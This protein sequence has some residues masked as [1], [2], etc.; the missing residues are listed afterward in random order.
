[1]RSARARPAT[2]HVLFLPGGTHALREIAATARPSTQETA[3]RWRR[4]APAALP[5][6]EPIAPVAR[7]QPFDD[8]AFQFEPQYT[9]CRALLY[10]RGP[11]AW[12]QAPGGRTVPELDA[13]AW[14]LR[15]HVE[16]ET[17][18]LDGQVVG[19][20]GNGKQDPTAGPG[21][22]APLHYAAFDVVWRHRTDL[23]PR[24]LWSRRQVLEQVIPKA[25]G[26]LSRVYAVPEQG[27][28]LLRAA[29]RLRYPGI[30]AKRRADPYREGTRW[31]AISARQADLPR[32]LGRQGGSSPIS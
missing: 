16:E 28:A 15:D 17:T 8:P 32:A 3:V 1:V 29:E 26:V 31:Y 23:R 21:S 12:F 2:T 7:A 14:E 5:E 9:G 24:P 6:V 19:L 4:A 30:I 11:A 27:C 20:D 25:N 13:F 18:I 10:L 22:G